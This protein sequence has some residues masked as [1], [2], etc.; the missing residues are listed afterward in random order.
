MKSLWA[1]LRGHKLSPGSLQL[2][3]NL[4]LAI[5]FG[6]TW[7]LLLFGSKTLAFS[8]VAWIYRI[9][10]DLFQH[11]LG[12]EW[13]RQSP[14]RF[15]L[16]RIE[17]YGYPFGTYLTYTDSIPL[18][19]IP[20]KLL[21]PWLGNN[22][23]Y[24][25]FWNLLSLIGQMLVGM[26]IIQEFSP[27][28]FQ[29]ILGASLLV[30]SPPLLFRTFGHDALTAQW[31]ILAAIWLVILEYRRHTLWRG[32]WLVLFALALLVHLY[33][34]AMLLP[35]WI[36]H[37]FFRTHRNGEKRF[38]W[39]AEV[40]ATLGLFLLTCTS[41][42]LFSLKM[43]TLQGNGLNY[44]TW[45]LNGFFNP[46]NFST[47]LKELAAGTNGQYE[48]YSYLG[49]GNLFLLP[50]GLVFTLQ[51]DYSRRHASF[52]VPLGIAA[53]VLALFALSNQA[54]VNTQMIWNIS[55]PG[56]AQRLFS[57]FQS[58]GRFIWPVFYLLVLFGLISI[59]RNMR[60]PTL[61]LLVALG[62][63]LIDVQP[64]YFMKKNSVLDQYQTSLQADFWKAAAGTNRHIILLPVYSEAGNIYEPIAI[65]ARQN[66]LTLNYGYFSR[67]PYGAMMQYG[68]A[69]WDNLK[70][71][72]ADPE[73]LYIF[74]EAE[75]QKAAGEYLARSMLICQVDG[76][77]VV[78]SAENKVRGANVDLAGICTSP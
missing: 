53:G 36:I 15:P 27:S 6:T 31:I 20:F 19:G 7:F 41:L 13:F 37:L 10:G 25:G 47:F 70:A 78:F 67:G 21:S 66:N 32:A 14:W 24:L 9:G 64:L 59:L 3:L 55:L 60:A 46:L 77:R 56:F 30:L 50:I 29:R 40:L 69:A 33:F 62:L 72:K 23:Q 51:K 63:Q 11:Q 76:L 17:A 8:H 4:A 34:V 5:Y 54:Y 22:F 52:L 73:T 38:A 74:W 57:L 58:T 43:D 68:Q 28:I 26:F 42:G 61:I 71:G 2:I 39:L 48:G 35:F 12:W 49:L 75:G 45:N 65:Y 1:K 16:G 18:L 44:Y